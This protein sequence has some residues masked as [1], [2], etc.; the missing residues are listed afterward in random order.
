WP[1]PPQDGYPPV[2]RL[3]GIHQV[4]RSRDVLA[5]QLRVRIVHEPH[6]PTRNRIGAVACGHQEVH[7]EWPL[8]AAHE[9]AQ[10]NEAPLE[11]AED[12]ELAVGVGCGDLLTQLANATRDRR[13]VEDDP[14]ELTPAGLLET[15]RAW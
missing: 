12:E 15:R 13:F 6:V 7:L 3:P 2:E 10:E 4:F 14:L 8:D 1:T 5:P 11:E 9:I